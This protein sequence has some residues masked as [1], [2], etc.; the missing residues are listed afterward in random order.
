VAASATKQPETALAAALTRAGYSKIEM[1]VYP[2]LLAFFRAGGTRG[3]LLSIATRVEAELSGRGHLI[4]GTH[5]ARAP[6]RQ[7]SDDAAGRNQRALQVPPARPSSPLGEV[8]G[9]SKSAL[10]AV[11]AVPP[12]SPPSRG[13]EGL[14]AHDA[15]KAAATPVREPS[16]A[17]RAAALSVARSIAVTVLDTYR[18]DGIA[19]GEWT[20]AE[21]L[22]ASKTKTMHGF[23][24]RECTRMVANAPSGAKLKTIVK[25]HEAQ[26]IIQRAAEASDAA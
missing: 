24:L 1:Q 17:Q 7:P 20:V 3:Q 13:G 12:S 6:S 10:S 22:R 16:A 8:G 4:A 23:I 18:I 15:H 25:P 5:H 21:A 14:R 11:L 2:H 19:L 26:R 9:H